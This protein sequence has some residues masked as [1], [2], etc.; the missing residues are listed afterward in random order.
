[1]ALQKTT[2]EILNELALYQCCI[3]DKAYKMAKNQSLGLKVDKCALREIAL[4]NIM[5]ERLKCFDSDGDT[6]P[7][8]AVQDDLTYTTFTGVVSGSGSISEST[9][10]T[11]LT[12]TQS[13]GTTAGDSATHTYGGN[14]NFVVGQQYTL[15]FTLTLDLNS[16]FEVRYGNKTLKTYRGV[17]SAVNTSIT[18]DVTD[19]SDKLEFKLTNANIT[20]AFTNSTIVM[21]LDSPP[22]IVAAPSLTEVITITQAEA[23]LE[24]LNDI[25]GCVWCDDADDIL[26]D[27]VDANLLN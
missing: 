26:D 11:Q 13:A 24:Q 25:C 27:T 2:Q 12:L 14:P 16:I 1:M 19:A 3:A 4:G 7:T 22:V 8:L 15:A 21:D 18:F 9:N 6:D 5:I 20:A 23:L 17:R 10:A